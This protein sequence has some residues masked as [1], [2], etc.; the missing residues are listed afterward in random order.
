MELAMINQSCARC[1][2]IINIILIILFPP[3]I[4]R[5]G[6]YLLQVQETTLGRLKDLLKVTKVVNGKNRN[7]TMVLL[8]IWLIVLLVY[9]ISSPF[10]SPCKNTANRQIQ[11]CQLELVI[12]ITKNIL[13]CLPLHVFVV[14]KKLQRNSQSCSRFQ[15]QL[16]H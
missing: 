5:R 10:P 2:V 6:C 3:Q 1:L 12:S 13:E 7:W 11:I 8:I 14:L 15:V 16:T 9:Y 4:L